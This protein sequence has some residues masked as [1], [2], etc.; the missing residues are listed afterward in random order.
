MTTETAALAYARRA[1]EYTRLLGTMEATSAADRARVCAWAAE[2]RGVTLDVGCGPGHWTGWLDGLR[3][4]G[5]LPD[6][7]S[8]AGV[9]PAAPFLAH[10]ERQHPHLDF[11]H[12][13]AEHLPF[14]DGTIGGILAWYSLIHTAPERLDDALAEFARVLPSAGH[15]CIGFFTG[16]RIAQFDHAVTPAIAWPVDALAD[17]VERAGFAVLSTRTRHDAGARPHGDL[18]ARLR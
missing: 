1:D 13:D 6:V 10:A 17:R 14:A 18:V 12:A 11:H 4:A 15:L 2:L 7:T 16:P 8:V 3:D 5:E 9:E